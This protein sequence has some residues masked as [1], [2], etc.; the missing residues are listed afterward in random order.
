[1]PRQKYRRAPF[2]TGPRAAR[3][4]VARRYCSAIVRA[5]TS[6]DDRY[7]RDGNPPAAARIP[8]DEVAALFIA[9]EAEGLVR[10]TGRFRRGEPV[11]IATAAGKTYLEAVPGS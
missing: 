1:M 3:N 4:I 6:H 5:R 7:H 8:R 2:F 11:Y 10:K 9:Y